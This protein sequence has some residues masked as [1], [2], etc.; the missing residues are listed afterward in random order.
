MGSTVI[1][2]VI[3]VFNVVKVFAVRLNPVQVLSKFH[4]KYSDMLAIVM[5]WQ[6]NYEKREERSF[7][8]MCTV[9]K[10]M[11]YWNLHERL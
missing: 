7:I 8:K 5:T 3:N 9:Y 4:A 1:I 11:T 6:Y 10:T 2:F